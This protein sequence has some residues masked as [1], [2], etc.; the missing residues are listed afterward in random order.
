MKMPNVTLEAKYY[1]GRSPVPRD[2]SLSFGDGEVSLSGNDI[3]RTCPASRLVVSPRVG[4]ADRF[5]A[6]PDGGQCQCA[7]HS[8][9]DLL[10]QEVRSEGPVAWLEERFAVAVASVA[11]TVCVLL[12][13]YFYGLPA[14][15]ESVV[16]RIP[17][18]TEV[19][20]GRNVLDWLDDNVWFEASRVD[21]ET[22]DSL[23]E[24]FGEL[25][26]GLTMS[27]HI[28][29][30]FRH[31]ELLGPNAFALPGGTIV[32]T[33][34]MVELAG[35]EEEIL[36]VL[37]HEIGHVEERHSMRQ[38]LQSSGIALLAAT[39]TAD[40]ATVSTTVAGLPAIL[41]QTKYS[42][43]FETEADEFAFA[44][45][46]RNNISPGVFADLME[47]LDTDNELYESLSFLSTHPVTS[48]RIKRARA[49]GE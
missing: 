39:V 3:S 27:P 20:L 35:S 34:Q 30:E 28:S 43:S 29:L 19:R 24:R 14:A 44:M 32:M 45:L 1:D 15:A 10:P 18:E 12:L 2:V 4:S 46:K 5:I 31:S 48:D 17:V 40:A 49:A 16:A 8:S 33:D 23:T 22:R 11:V 21:Q 9:L 37:A 42:R 7:D 36:A 6:F 25:H 26:L 38:I 13:A 47:R 41:A